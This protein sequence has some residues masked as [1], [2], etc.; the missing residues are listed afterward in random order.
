M[1]MAHNEQEKRTPNV[2]EGN[3]SRTPERRPRFGMWVY[4]AII[5]F[6]VVHLFIFWSGGESNTFEYGTFLNYVEEGHGEEVVVINDKRIEGV[7]TQQAV[8]QS[9]VQGGRHQPDIHGNRPDA[10]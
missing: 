9:D 6:L 4:F 1:P 2:R 5:F 10:P 7:Y 8:E 3:G